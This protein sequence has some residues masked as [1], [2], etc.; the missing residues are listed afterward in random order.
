MSPYR[1]GEYI[2]RGVGGGYLDLLP[3]VI[4]QMLQ[5]QR[6]VEERQRAMEALR[7]SKEK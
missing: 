1:T 3:T 2:V 7:E 6:L 4:E 5:Q